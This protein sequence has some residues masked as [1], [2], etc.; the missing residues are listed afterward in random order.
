MTFRFGVLQA[1]ATLLCCLLGL[2]M[3]PGG[4]AAQTPSLPLAQALSYRP[5]GEALLSF[6]QATGLDL[7]YDPEVVAG[8]WTRSVSP[9]MTSPEAVLQAMLQGTGLMFFRLS[10]G[11]YALQAKDRAAAQRGSLAGYVLDKATGVPLPR[12]NVRLADASSRGAATDAGGVFNIATLLPGRYVLE[13]SHVGYETAVDTVQVRPDERTELRV[14]LA[15]RTVPITPIIVENF[16][17]FDHLRALTNTAEREEL[18]QA[19][20][21]GTRDAVR[22]INSLTGVR[23]GDAMADVHIQ[24][25]EA[26]EHQFRLDGVPIFEPVHLRGLLGAFNPFALQ[27]IV[28]HKAGFSVLEGSQLSGVIDAEHALS[29]P[30]GHPLDVQA[31]P[32]S[33]NARMN[34]HAGSSDG[35]RAQFMAAYRTSLW[36]V[37]SPARLDSLLLDWNTPDQFLMRA[38]LLPLR[39]RA[40]LRY[41]ELVQRFDSLPPPAVPDLGFTDV[42]AA[43]RLQLRPGNTLYA[44]YYRGDNRLDS[45]RLAA[46][47]DTTNQALPNPD[48]Y[49]WFNENAQARWSLLLAPRLLLSTRLRSSLYDL[50]HDYN[51]LD[52]Q[53]TF[54]YFFPRERVQVVFDLTPADDGNRM[55]ETAL[56]ATLD[57]DHGGGGASVGFEAARTTHRFTMNDAFTRSIIH[58]ATAWRA[59]V[60]AEEKLRLGSRLTLTAGARLTYLDQRQAVYAEPRLDVRYQ[61]TTPLGLLAVRGATGLYRQFVNQFDISSISPSALFPAIRFWMPVDSSIAPP[62]AYHA[63]LDLLL[64]PSDAWSFRLES[65]YKRQPHLLR[66]DYPVLWER[67]FDVEDQ[68]VPTIT[69]QAEFLQSGEGYAYGAALVIERVGEKTRASARYEYNLARRE[70]AFEDSVRFENVPWSEPHRLDLALDWTPARRFIATV[71][72]RSIWGRSWGFRRAYYDFL[73]SDPTQSAVYGAFDFR[74][75]DRHRLPVFSQLDLGAAYTQR[76]G[77]AAV[78]LRLDLLNATGRR[79]VADRSLLQ[80]LQG[81]EV[82]FEPAARRLMP[83]TFSMALRLQW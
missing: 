5:L 52:N 35:L 7:T 75:P 43:A 18:T 22:S 28:V 79:N 67:D 82:A 61:F 58:D 16:Q 12:A 20:A 72:W 2:A 15:A 38:S 47:F 46:A 36:N 37:Y 8:K 57:L 63:A 56:D 65:Y 50:A 59:A 66:I 6:Q 34:L 49:T 70:Y 10:S 74:D 60:F 11:T 17:A 30:D 68:P 1:W 71:R 45:R 29:S 3:L 24:G 39:D 62:K 23:V 4:A 42:H 77:P 41:Q 55:R 51:A 48:R 76:F 31:D 64:Q 54:V 9:E 80:V 81:P 21:L 83:R 44:S 27:R 32:L 14:G 53:N 26:G 73:G 33:L 40:P 25:G 13:I 19:N 69:S 78:Q